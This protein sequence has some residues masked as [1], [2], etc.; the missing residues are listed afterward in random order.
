MHSPPSQLGPQGKIIKTAAGIPQLSEP[1]GGEVGGLD[2]GSRQGGRVQG[3]I[4][5][6]RRN[7]AMLEN[8]GLGSEACVGVKER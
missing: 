8:T 4:E 1:P 6:A 3:I 2:E 5:I 7:P